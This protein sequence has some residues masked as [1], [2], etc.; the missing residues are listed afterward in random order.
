MRWDEACDRRTATECFFCTPTTNGVPSNSEYK[1]GSE[2]LKA[3]FTA[4]NFKRWTRYQEATSSYVINVKI[5]SYNNGY[6]YDGNGPNRAPLD[7]QEKITSYNQGTSMQNSRKPI[8]LRPIINNCFRTCL[9]ILQQTP[10]T[11]QT[12]HKLTHMCALYTHY[13]GRTC[14]WI[15]YTFICH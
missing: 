13:S 11:S 12:A 15:I 2:D 5:A 7:E 4:S 8:Y 14:N 10:H 1:K 3:D 6:N 9:S